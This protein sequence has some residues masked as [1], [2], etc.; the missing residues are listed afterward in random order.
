MAQN[1]RISSSQQ[2][3]AANRDAEEVKELTAK[4]ERQNSILRKL[5]KGIR[6]PDTP[7]SED[8]ALEGLQ[9]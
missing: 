7:I 3:I 2:G 1:Y 4:K 5:V 8:E 6:K 9:E